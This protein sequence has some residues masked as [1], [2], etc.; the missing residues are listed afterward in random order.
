MNHIKFILLFLILVNS[1]LF[2][3]EEQ[4][5][6]NEKD[7]LEISQADLVVPYSLSRDWRLLNY[8]LISDFSLS[9]L[10]EVPSLLPISLE[11]IPLNFTASKEEMLAQFRSQQNW[12]TKKSFGVFT[13]YLGYA[14]FL[15]AMGLLGVHIYQWSNLK[16]API[17]PAAKP[18]NRY[19]FKK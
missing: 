1:I 19:D 6:P 11:G 16:N 12:D 7:S 15:G 4:N 8:P 2:S 17:S 5:K 18:F 14:Q 3:Q 9:Y 10:Y 13:E